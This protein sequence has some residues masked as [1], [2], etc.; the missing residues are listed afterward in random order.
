MSFSFTPSDIKRISEHLGAQPEADGDDT[1]F[2][3]ANP[4]TRQSVRLALHNGVQLPDGS[5]EA[6]AVV[7]TPYGYFEL[8]RCTSFFTFDPDEVIFLSVRDASISGIVVG[9]QS[10]C[11]MFSDVPRSVLSEDLAEI[12]PR[13]LMSAM[14]LA[15]TEEV[16]GE[17][18]P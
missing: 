4:S 14:Q 18:K 1:S 5:L 8:H 2:T 11:S 7:H 15:L 12:D 10:T 6:M 9:A 16:L 17:E 3:L 13:L